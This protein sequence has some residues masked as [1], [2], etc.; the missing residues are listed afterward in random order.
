M[1]FFNYRKF[2]LSR[3]TWLSMK[4]IIFLIITGFL[5]VYAT[6]YSQ[7]V[8]I[9][10][11]DIPLRQVFNAVKKQAGYVFFYDADLIKN[12]KPVTMDLTNAPV[13]K[14]LSETF[15][16][17]PFTWSIE[18]KTI[19]VVKKEENAVSVVPPQTD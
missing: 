2:L 5:Q 11:K 13:A 17:Q 16:E 8:S 3:Q 10:A 19:T 18:N 4:L 15:K 7:T 12:A 9:S 1:L 14:V 6:G